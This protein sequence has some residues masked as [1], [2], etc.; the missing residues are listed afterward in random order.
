[1]AEFGDHIGP[2]NICPN[3]T[4]ALERARALL[5]PGNGARGVLAG[6]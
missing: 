5:A 3:V 2:E 4:A 6:L 1:M